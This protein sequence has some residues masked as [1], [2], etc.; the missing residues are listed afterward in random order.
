M[1]ICWIFLKHF[2][3]PDCV[4]FCRPSSWILLKYS[5][6]FFMF[7]GRNIH[8]GRHSWIVRKN[9]QTHFIDY[10]AVWRLDLIITRTCIRNFILK[11]Y[12]AC[13]SRQLLSKATARRNNLS[14]FFGDQ[15][16]SPIS[17]PPQNNVSALLLQ[18]TQSRVVCQPPPFLSVLMSIHFLG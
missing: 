1:K 3:C 12:K 2:Y 14:G 9:V 15:K 13:C 11:P 7:E 18:W 16:I 17:Q 8:L 5:G 6:T 10:P 4:P